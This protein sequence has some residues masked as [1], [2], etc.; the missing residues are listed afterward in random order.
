LPG[1][2][3]DVALEEFEGWTAGL[4]RQAVE[5]I[6][7]AGDK[8]A[9]EFSREVRFTFLLAEAK[10]KLNF[11]QAQAKLERKRR[12]HLLPDIARLDSISRYESHL[13]R[14]LF[15]T[16]HEIERLQAARA[17]QPVPPPVTIDVTI[18]AP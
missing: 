1:V 8:P 11:E 5:A 14:S 18:D 13:E 16:L 3:D 7:K 9:S 12:R 4:L 2:P 6:G 10:A 17:G 15:K